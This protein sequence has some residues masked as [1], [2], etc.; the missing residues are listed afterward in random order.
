MT[1]SLID[2]ELDRQHDLRSYC[3]LLQ[4]SQGSAT[5]ASNVPVDD[6]VRTFLNESKELVLALDKFPDIESVSQN[7]A[8]FRSFKR[9]KLVCEVLM[10]DAFA[11][12]I[13]EVKREMA[14]IRSDL[15]RE[16]KKTIDEIHKHFSEARLLC[17]D[18]TKIS[19]SD[20]IELITEK[21][22]NGRYRVNPIL[23]KTSRSTCLMIMEIMRRTLS[24]S[25]A[26]AMQYCP[27]IYREIGLTFQLRCRNT[28][29]LFLKVVE[30]ENWE[31]H[32]IFDFNSLQ[33]VVRLITLYNS[34]EI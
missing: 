16:S 31:S 9:Q 20:A 7:D 1:D 14:E 12:F 32:P 29:K 21:I 23:D 34:N 19:I 8:E 26:S 25:K 4:N 33:E 22:G 10:I 30:T 18:G 11:S 3:D 15:S 13:P 24:I 28:M 6:P 5:Q 17:E 2:D 27:L